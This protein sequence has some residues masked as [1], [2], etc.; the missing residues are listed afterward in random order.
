MK[1]FRIRFD[2]EKC[3]GCGACASVSDNWTIEGSKARP[4]KVEISE[5]DL[6]SNEEAA[7]L[8]PLNAIKIKN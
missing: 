5:T 2:R 7:K 6:E 1:T 4:K 3:L 8:C